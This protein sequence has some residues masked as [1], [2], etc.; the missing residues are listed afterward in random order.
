MSKSVG[1]I[2]DVLNGISGLNMV[3]THPLSITTI[4]ASEIMNTMTTNSI[5]SND[6]MKQK[7][8]K[9]D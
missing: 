3:L 8:R 4:L 5:Q 2:F 1:L 6:G 9:M 7:S